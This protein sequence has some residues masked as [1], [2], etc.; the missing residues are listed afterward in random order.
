MAGPHSIPPFPADLSREHFGHWLSGFAAGEACFFLRVNLRDRCRPN[1]QA[2]FDI[3][4]R[5]D[6]GAVL[7]LIRSYWQAGHVRTRPARKRPTRDAQPKTEYT[8]DHW[9]QLALILVP[10]FDAFPLHAKKARD[11]AIWKEAVVLGYRVAQR[12]FG[13]RGYGGG[14]FPKWTTAEIEYYAALAAT[15]QAQRAFDAA[16]IN[17]PARAQLPAERGLFDPPR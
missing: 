3:H 1:P 15:L 17:L 7:R 6:D 9:R 14:R 13:S 2:R 5:A 8:V 11:F 16:S 10:H 12:P 4:L